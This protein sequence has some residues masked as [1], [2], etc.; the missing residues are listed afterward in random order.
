MTLGLAH[1]RLQQL[2]CGL[3]TL[4]CTTNIVHVTCKIIMCAKPRPTVTVQRCVRA[5]DFSLTQ[6]IVAL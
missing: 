2:V 1:I 4:E 3:P 5:K 6:L